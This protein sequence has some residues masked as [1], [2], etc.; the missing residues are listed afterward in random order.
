MR[1]FLLQWAFSMRH[2]LLQPSSDSDQAMPPVYVFG[3]PSLTGEDPDNL[4]PVSAPAQ[5]ISSGKRPVVLA[6]GTYATQVG[7]ICSRV[8]SPYT[9]SRTSA[10]NDGKRKHP[11]TVGA[12][13]MK[14]QP[15]SR[16]GLLD[17]NLES[18]G[19]HGFNHLSKKKKPRNPPVQTGNAALN[20]Q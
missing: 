17:D 20:L 6:D 11:G 15:G 4:T 10:T 2:S 18:Q 14:L 3:C 7:V 8:C 9:R 13:V 1:S 12:T 16:S 5:V 19:A